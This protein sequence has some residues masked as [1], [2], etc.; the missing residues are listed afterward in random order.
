MITKDA[1]TDS[2]VF[3]VHRIQDKLFYEIPRP[4]LDRDFRLVV[5]RRGTIRGVG[6]A[7]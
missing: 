3:I 1:V 7:G 6:Y 4:M 5:D 2:G